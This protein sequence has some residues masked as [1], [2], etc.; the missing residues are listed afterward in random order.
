MTGPEPADVVRR[1]SAGAADGD[2]AAF[3]LIADGFVN[4]AAGPQG[5]EGLRLTLAVVAHDLADIEYHEERV[6]A[7]GDLVVTEIRLEGTHV[8]STMPLLQGIEPTGARVT[9][10]FVHTWRVADGL[11]V[12]HWATRD[13]LGLLVQLGAWPPAG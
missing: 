8:A 12:E 4:H 1:F 10:T 2:D 11:I 7:E 6:V 9:W 3:E 13:D 5:R